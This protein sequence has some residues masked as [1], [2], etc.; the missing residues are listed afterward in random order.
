MLDLKLVQRYLMLNFWVMVGVCLL[1]VVL[2]ETEVLLPLEQFD[3]PQLEFF[4]Q[5]VMEFASIIVIPVALK[6]FSIP[7]VRHRLLEHKG[8]A[9]ITWGTARIQML[10]VPMTIDTFCIIRPCGQVLAIWASFFC[11]VSSSSIPLWADVWTRQPN[12]LK[13]IRL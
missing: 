2:Y 3:N 12:P 6:L 5:V 1:I 7:S 8:S 4:L 9:L 13:K 11:C 10:C